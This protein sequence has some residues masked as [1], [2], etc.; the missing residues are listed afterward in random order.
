MI[1]A[2]LRRSPVPR[3]QLIDSLR[4]VVGNAGEHVGEPGLRINIIQFA[5]DDN[6]VHYGRASSTAPA[7]TASKMPR[8]SA[9]TK[10]SSAASSQL[11][12]R[13]PAEAS[14]APTAAVR[15]P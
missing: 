8:S 13:P 11:A 15:G 10:Q 3:K 4:R 9:A 14:T 12:S 2:L 7:L 1:S 6:A 5:G